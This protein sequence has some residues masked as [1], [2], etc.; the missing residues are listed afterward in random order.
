MDCRKPVAAP[1]ILLL[2]KQWPSGVKSGPRDPVSICRET[3][4]TK[5]C[6]LHGLHRLA[7]G[8]AGRPESIKTLYI[9]PGSPLIKSRDNS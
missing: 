1:L 4:R 2:Y 3:F 8:S 6:S 9:Q 5:N 7:Q